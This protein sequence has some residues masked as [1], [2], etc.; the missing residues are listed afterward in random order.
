[1]SNGADQYRVARTNRNKCPDPFLAQYTLRV[2]VKQIRF[3]L[4]KRLVRL[5]FYLLALWPEN[6]D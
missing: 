5:L 3:Y 4:F 1:M 6:F 2:P